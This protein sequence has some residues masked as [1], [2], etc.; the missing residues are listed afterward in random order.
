[1]PSSSPNMLIVIWLRCNIGSIDEWVAVLPI[2]LLV[3]LARLNRVRKDR[4]SSVL[5]EVHNQVRVFVAAFRSAYSAR[6]N[7]MKNRYLHRQIA[8]YKFCV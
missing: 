1:M 6:G 8:G 2:R 7:G 4:F 5:K 3:A